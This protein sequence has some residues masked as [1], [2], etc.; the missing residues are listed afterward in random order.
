MASTFHQDVE[1]SLAHCVEG[2]DLFLQRQAFRVDR[3]G[4]H[5]LTSSAHLK[6]LD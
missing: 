3:V 5:I 1:F 6:C 4:T 2:R